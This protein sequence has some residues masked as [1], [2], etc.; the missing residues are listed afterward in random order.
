MRRV[1]S[2]SYAAPYHRITFSSNTAFDTP[3]ELFELVVPENHN[4]TPNE[5]LKLFRESCG[6]GGWVEKLLMV[7]LEHKPDCIPKRYK[8]NSCE[9]M[10]QPD[11]SGWTPVFVFPTRPQWIRVER[12]PVAFLRPEPMEAASP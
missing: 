8:G 12:E 2:V 6:A 1:H 5:V 3:Y 7:A 11:Y 9:F 10:I 4:P